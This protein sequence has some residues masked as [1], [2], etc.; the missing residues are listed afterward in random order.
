MENICT[1]TTYNVPRLQ[2]AWFVLRGFLVFH[3]HM[4]SKYIYNI[5]I[6]PPRAIPEGI[7][8]IIYIYGQCIDRVLRGRER[9]RCIYLLTQIPLAHVV[10]NTQ[11]TL[12]FNWRQESSE[13]NIVSK[14]VYRT[15][16]Y[17]SVLFRGRRGVASLVYWS[18]RV[19]LLPHPMIMI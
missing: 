5:E 12:R 14:L 9:Y 17:I 19:L 2:S 3:Q 10:T 11:S 7:D 15:A 6:R 8:M 13:S 4:I 16:P 1:T 18:N